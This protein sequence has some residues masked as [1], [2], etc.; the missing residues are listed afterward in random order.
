MASWL[1]EPSFPGIYSKEPSIHI[2]LPQ[3]RNYEADET[4]VTE[5][6]IW[7]DE[8]EIYRQIRTGENWNLGDRVQWRGKEYVIG[9]KE[10]KL[11][12]GLWLFYYTIA[13]KGAF[14]IKPYEHVEFTGRRLAAT[15]LER[16]TI[17]SQVDN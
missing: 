13:K 15:V 7:R 9:E 16:P 4:E 2:G 3:G 5:T 10:G 11:E 17:K 14:N 1:G 8:G 6:K 12:K